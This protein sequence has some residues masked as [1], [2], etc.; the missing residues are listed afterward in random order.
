MIKKKTATG[1][2]VPTLVTDRSAEVAT[3]VGAGPLPFPALGW[4]GAGGAVAVLVST[5]PGA[6]LGPTATV[7]VKTALPGACGGLE[8]RPVPGA[9]TGGAVHDQPP[10]AESETNVVP[11]GN[12][13]E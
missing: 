9:P 12:V 1:S 5:V 8:Q 3:G 10:G 13:S 6:T 2:G 7:G 11:A 4:G